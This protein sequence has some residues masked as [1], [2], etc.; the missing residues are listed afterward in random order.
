MESENTKKIMTLS[1]LGSAVVVWI[2]VS[3]L[4][5]TL[6]ATWGPMARLMDQDVFRHGIPLIGAIATF[7]LL[8]FNKKVT[9]FTDEVITEIKKVVWPSYP[10]TSAMTIVVCIMVIISGV[11]VGVFDM[12][13]G[14]IVKYLINI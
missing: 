12:F 2:V 6:A 13:S 9:V 3:V 5:D 14:Y 10:E 7:C 4:L 11:L 1:F 8:Q